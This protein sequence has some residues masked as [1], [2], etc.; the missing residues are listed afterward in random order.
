MKNPF[1][2]LFL[3]FK[4]IIYIKKNYLQIRKKKVKRKFHLH[5]RDN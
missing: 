2:P 5:S 4:M 3:I 1:D